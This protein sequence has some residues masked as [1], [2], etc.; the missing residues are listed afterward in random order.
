MHKAILRSGFGLTLLFFWYFTPVIA[1]LPACNQIPYMVCD[2]TYQLQSEGLGDLVSFDSVG[3]TYYGPE[4]YFRFSPAYSDELLLTAYNIYGYQLAVVILQD[5]LQ[6]PCFDSLGGSR[7]MLS[8]SNDPVRTISLGQVE[9][10]HTYYLILDRWADDLLQFGLQLSCPSACP[11]PK[12]LSVSAI[13]PNSAQLHWQNNA[14]TSDWEVEIQPFN[15]PFSGT[16]SYTGTGNTLTANNLQPLTQ[17]HWR[18]R[19][20]CSTTEFSNWSGEQI[21]GTGP[22][23]SNVPGLSCQS[24]TTLTFQ[25]G[26]DLIP[27]CTQQDQNPNG[28]QEVYARFRPPYDGFFQMAFEVNPDLI[29]LSVLRA[30]VN[31]Q[32]VQSPWKC[33]GNFGSSGPVWLETGFLK[34]DS[35]Y[36]FA[37]EFDRQSN[38]Q[39]QSFGVSLYCPSACMVPD[40]VY[41]T[42]ITPNSATI[43]WRVH[44]N[45]TQWEVRL[46]GLNP[47]GNDTTFYTTSTNSL[48]LTNLTRG[49]LYR[50][51]ARAFCGPAVTDWS[52]LGEFLNPPDCGLFPP[53]TCENPVAVPFET[54][55]GYLANGANCQIYDLRGFDQ[56]LTFDI[57]Q[58]GESRFFEKPDGK[59]VFWR[60]QFANEDCVHAASWN[61]LA[62]STIGATVLLRHLTAGHYE[63]LFKQPLSAPQNTLTF[64]LHCS[65]PCEAP[66]A[67]YTN[68]HPGGAGYDYVAMWNGASGP[69]AFDAELRD[70][71]GQVSTATLSGSG[72]H[73]LKY[74]FNLLPGQVYEWRV[75]KKCTLTG[76]LSG[77]TEWTRF[78]TMPDCQD[79]VLLSCSNV[80]AFTGS[81]SPYQ[82]YDECPDI[83]RWGSTR[84]YRLAPAVPGNYLIHITQSNGQPVA[85]ELIDEWNCHEAV[86]N[87]LT[88]TSDTTLNLGAL[89]VNHS[90]F[91][92]VLQTSALP[93]SQTFELL[94]PCYPL[95]LGGHGTLSPDGTA[96]VSWDYPS[97]QF[98]VELVPVQQPF[99]G[100]GNYFTSQNNPVFS[101]LNPLL[102]YHYRVR[103][104]CGIPAPW[105]SEVDLNRIFSCAT[106][107]QLSCSTPLSL[108][109]GGG[110]GLVNNSFG[111]TIPL[112]GQERY[113]RFESP[114]TGTYTI[115]IQPLSGG[116][117]ARA[118]WFA[119]CTAGGTNNN[120][121]LASDGATIV[122]VIA[123]QTYTLVFDNTNVERGT[124]SIFIHCDAITPVAPANDNAFDFAPWGNL[125]ADSV[126]LNA[127]CQSYS[128]RYA[129]AGAIDPN[130]ALAP[131]NWLDGPEKTVWFYFQ[132]PPG[133]TVEVAV[134]SDSMDPQVALIRFDSM[135]FFGYRV[136]ASGENLASGSTNAS[137]IYTG[138]HPGERYLLMVDGVNGSTGEFCLGIR[139]EPTLMSTTGVC[140]TYPQAPAPATSPD[141]WI[142]LYAVNG[143]HTNGP[144]LGAIQTAD[145]LGNI[146]VSSEIHPEA[147]VFPNGQKILPRY[148]HIETEF[149]PVSPVKLRIFFTENDLAVY[150]LTPPLDSITVPQLGISHYD[151]GSEDCD[152]N[153]NVLGGSSVP[154]S[155]ATYQFVGQN[156]IF[157]LET[158][159]TQFSEFGATLDPT[160]KVRETDDVL[161]SVHIFPIPT[162]DQLSVE[163]TALVEEPVN[164]T[165][166]NLLGEQFWSATR[167]MTA[168]QNTCKVRLG[169]LPAGMYLLRFETRQ[170]NAGVYRVVKW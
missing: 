46:I 73:D 22:V 51:R 6:Y 43:G 65:L 93:T 97:T 168:G 143:P 24:V 123:G 111:G 29:Q 129:T 147:P 160:I 30:Q 125:L 61:C 53:L 151:G 18:V 119:G 67:P 33:L 124:Y 32:C 59:D 56:V 21:F 87:C 133:G 90:Y 39:G 55:Y 136:L 159:L 86:L 150:N 109:I 137:L 161:N 100:F 108:Y 27:V 4:T 57:I 114:V 85:Y 156:G 36:L 92:K 71:Q 163:W 166:C 115:D 81:A 131:G 7:A 157:Y 95:Y 117:M 88:A 60:K 3:T 38:H 11:Y 52:E 101:G 98:E 104:I 44:P 94:C 13:G 82:Y 170:G 1:Q 154:V 25:S 15:T 110:D 5:S 2:S 152:P 126:A 164:I 113:V 12:Q 66:T 155:N 70:A 146:V 116:A 158:T 31:P 45:Q 76:E 145:N 80:V 28:G 74:T 10:G 63:L 144:L 68:I 102:D 120:T 169:H 162:T 9:A 16:A 138:L 128:N 58:D 34:A 105:S 118:G 112:Y 165:I 130:P 8:F 167:E 19:N 135:G 132:A 37:F 79:A 148:F 35:N 106:T 69:W 149:Q 62:D 127:P 91:L 49:R 153:N 96:H 141:D 140:Q 121:A 75:R 142:N 47:A 42:D 103:P 17:Y 64:N 83:T 134:S 77:W 54:G 99:S 14:L 89:S 20:R 84:L 48:S 50:W 139:D 23:C 40:S 122:S 78:Q 26:P 107:P 41:S 72:Q